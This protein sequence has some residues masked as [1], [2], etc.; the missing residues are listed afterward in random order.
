MTEQSEII[1]EVKKDAIQNLLKNGKRPDERRFDEYRKI[2]FNPDFVPKAEGSCFVKLGDTQVVVGVKLGVMEPYADTPD[3]GTMTVN[4]ELGPLASPLFEP[5]P[6]DAQSIEISRVVDRGI[7]ESKMIDLEALCIKPGEKVWNV[8]IDVHPLDDHGNLFDAASYA[9]VKALLSARFP[10]LEDDGEKIVYGE[11]T[12]P[13]PIKDKPVSCTFIKVGD[14]LI[15]DPSYEEEKAADARFTLV[16]DQEENLCAAQKGGLG[17]FTE[18]DIDA[19]I[20]TAIQ[21]GREIRKLF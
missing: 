3:Q 2:S 5:G 18:K 16:T 21:Q 20:E 19:I 11:K 15:I 17:G 6:P 1:W 13:L 4:C 8:F 14:S 9:A 7:R 10:K 12:G